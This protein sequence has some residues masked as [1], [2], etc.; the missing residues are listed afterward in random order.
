MFVKQALLTMLSVRKRYIHDVL[1]LAL[2]YTPDQRR[3]LYLE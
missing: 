3:W 2:G 1:K